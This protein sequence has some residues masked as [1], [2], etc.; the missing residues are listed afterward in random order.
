MDWNSETYHVKETC[1]R[2]R[3]GYSASIA[4]PK[5]ESS[6]APVNI[7]PTGIVELKGHRRSQAERKLSLGP[8]YQDNDLMFCSDSGVMLDSCNIVKRVFNPALK[9]AGLRR[10][11]FHDLRHTAGS[12]MVMAGVDLRTVQKILGHRTPL[13]TMRYAHLSDEHM[14]E[15]AAKLQDRLKRKPDSAMDTLWTPP[16][17]GTEPQTV[18]QS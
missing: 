7:T 14:A 18:V 5:T 11:R 10:I 9:A 17:I 2:A 6:I 4:E 12:Q 16:E 3:G 13:M 1:L 15:A 8:D